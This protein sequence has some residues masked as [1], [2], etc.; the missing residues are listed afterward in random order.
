[1]IQ[2]APRA[3]AAIAI[4]ISA[5]QG[6]RDHDRYEALAGDLPPLCYACRSTKGPLRGCP[7]RHIASPQSER[8]HRLFIV[9]GQ[10][11]TAIDR[12]STEPRR[13]QRCCSTIEDR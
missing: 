5:I 8:S 9:N 12:F 4:Y 7:W 10:D 2:R 11:S 13:R 3:T 6:D 1:M